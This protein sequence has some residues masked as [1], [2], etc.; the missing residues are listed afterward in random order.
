MEVLIGDA[1]SQGAFGERLAV[2]LPARFAVF[3]EGDLGTGKTTLARG[4]LHGL[5]HRGAVRSPTYTLIEPYEIGLRRL[6]HLD[7]Y[8]LSNPEELDYLGLRDLAA[9]DAVLLVEWPERGAGALPAPDLRIRLDYLPDGRRLTLDGAS[10]SG[11]ALV[12]A[13]VCAGI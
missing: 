13:L 3:L 1:A 12:Q 10:E 9:E 7:L 5:G 11:Q 6:Y 2:Y 4:I 8:R